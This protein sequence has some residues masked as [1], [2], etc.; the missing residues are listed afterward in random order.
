VSF[1][2]DASLVLIPSGIN[3]SKVYSQKP[4]DGTG[5]L[6]FSR[7]STA[8]R[9]NSAGLIEKV[10]TNFIRNSSMVG[11][12]AGT[13]GTLPTNWGTSPF[14][15]AGL[16]R[17]VIGVGSENGLPYVDVRING[18]A[19]GTAASIFTE[20][21]TPASPSQVFANSVY[22]K[23]IANPNPALSV[24][25]A[26]NFFN[27]TT[28]VNS[29][30]TTIVPTNDLT[31]FVGI[32][33]ASSSTL[34][35][36]TTLISFGFVIA[37]TYDFTIRIAAPQMELGDAASDWIPTTTAA[38]TVG[39]TNNVPRLDYSGGATCPSLLLEQQRT[40]LALQSEAFD[41]AS[42]TKYLG[43]QIDANVATSP[44]GTSSADRVRRTTTGIQGIYQNTNYATTGLYTESVFAKA[45]TSNFIQFSDGSSPLLVVNLT[46]GA[47]TANTGFFTNVSVQSYPNGWYRIIYTRNRTATGTQF[48]LFFWPSDASTLTFNT[49]SA[50]CSCFAWG[51]QL[52]AGSYVSSYIPTTT[53]A[54]TR[55]VDIAEKL[56]IGSLIG[57]PAGTIFLQVQ[58]RSLGYGR[59]FISLQD[60]S[61]ATN[62]IRIECTASNRWRI[63]IRNAS[64]TI[65]DQTISTGSAFTTGNYKIAYAYNTGTNEIAFYV[66]GVSLFTG[67]AAS[68]PTACV[69]LFLGSRFSG[70]YDLNVSDSFDQ[71]LLFKTRLSN[72]QLAELTTL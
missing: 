69:N 72:A 15:F 42:W 64:A 32:H 35:L 17:T 68:I 28:F 54:V 3:T 1:Y 41:N 71:V 43:A 46:N 18:T 61:Y 2:D 14:A 66:N 45:D 10:R 6:T 19:T 47:I 20:A 56:G 21:T 39:P 7:A 30:I 52:E 50:T 26:T 38:V 58:I 60:A 67:T 36:A 62:S 13:P 49:T 24:Q 48:S 37:S 63:Q 40:N 27:G 59:S 4:T 12:V 25:L 16:T 8:T 23:Y 65:L 11:A 55:L 57:S 22:L 51:G 70:G 29:Q 44:D 9:T 33:T 31:R 5:D 53:A 34:N